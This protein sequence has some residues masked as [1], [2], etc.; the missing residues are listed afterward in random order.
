MCVCVCVSDGV[1]K[2]TCDKA[3]KCPI[4]LTAVLSS[5]I[6]S[7]SVLPVPFPH[8]SLPISFRTANVQK[9]WIGTE[10]LKTQWVCDPYGKAYKR[11]GSLNAKAELV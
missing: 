11:G 7:V 9:T 3:Q 4:F 8:I 6:Q 1:R 5:S 2:G 10:C